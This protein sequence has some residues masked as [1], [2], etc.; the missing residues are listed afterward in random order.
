M[1]I[2]YI[3]IYIYYILYL[4]FLHVQVLAKYAELEMG[5][6]CV[7]TSAVLQILKQVEYISKFQSVPMFSTICPC[8]L[9]NHEP[10]STRHL[11]DSDP[12]YVP[13]WRSEASANKGMKVSIGNEI[14]ASS[15]PGTG[16]APVLDVRMI[17]SSLLQSNNQRT[18][19]PDIQVIE[20]L[21][22]VRKMSFKPLKSL[23]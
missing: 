21:L 5:H 19:T 3:I 14:K 22:D 9:I 10:A 2:I 6:F 11:A 23:F 15:E 7:W 18:K 1:Y 17:L 16:V 4:V 13:F 12:S 20:V 8:N